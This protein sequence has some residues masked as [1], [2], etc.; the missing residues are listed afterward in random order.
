MRKRVKDKKT[1]KP[2]DY[3]VSA[4]PSLSSLIPRG[5]VDR[6]QALHV[7]AMSRAVTPP[8]AL[9][10]DSSSQNVPACTVLLWASLVAQG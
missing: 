8:P 1:A 10:T 9:P 5:F 4:V 2:D 6:W 3:E 7:T